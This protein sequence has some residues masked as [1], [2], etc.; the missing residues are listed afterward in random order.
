[1]NRVFLSAHLRL[2]DNP[3]R[4]LCVKPAFDVEVNRN[5]MLS[6]FIRELPAVDLDSTLLKRFDFLCVPLC[7]LW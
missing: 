3:L 1:M 5:Q 6:D 7:P 2:F 4:A